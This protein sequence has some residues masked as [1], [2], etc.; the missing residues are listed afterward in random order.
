MKKNKEKNMNFKLKEVFSLTRSLPVLTN[1]E[2]P[3]KISYR[4]LKLLKQCSVEMESMEKARIKLVDKYA[5]T[6]EE[7]EASPD[8]DKGIK[9]AEAKIPDFQREFEILLEEEVEIDF[10]PILISDLGDISLS[11]KDLLSLQIILKEK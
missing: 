5:E 6:E 7:R 8:K 2:L 4:L 11:A 9:V 3:I 1:K 10:E